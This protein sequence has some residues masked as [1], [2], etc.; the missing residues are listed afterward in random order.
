MGLE[1]KVILRSVFLVACIALSMTAAAEASE[2]AQ[3]FTLICKWDEGRE[4]ETLQIYGDGHHLFVDRG[5]EIIESHEDDK[6]VQHNWVLYSGSLERINIGTDLDPDFVRWTYTINRY[7]GHVSVSDYTGI[8]KGK[9][10]K[11]ESP[12][13]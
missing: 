2:D 8:R 10:K 1:E 6:I 11:A 3:Q 9:C 7:T 12:L 5:L 13:F 4:D